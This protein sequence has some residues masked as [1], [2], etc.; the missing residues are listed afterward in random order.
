MKPRPKPP[1][2]VR[3]K[4]S[5]PELADMACTLRAGTVRVYGPENGFA[6]LEADELNQL[7]S[8]EQVFEASKTVLRQL[9]GLRKLRGLIAGEVEPT[10]IE[11]TN[12]TGH[13]ARMRLFYTSPHIYVVT[14]ERGEK[15]LHPGGPT[16]SEAW[17]KVARTNPRVHA[18][19][20]DLGMP[21]DLPRLR[22][23]FEHIWTELD[24]KN[25]KRAVEQMELA[26]LL[27]A[28]A[29]KR[30]LA[31]VNRSDEAAHSHF[32]YASYKKAFP[33]K[34]ATGWLFAV[35][36][37]WIEQKVSSGRAR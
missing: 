19:L 22:R 6:Y 29:A 8:P 36:N 31:T 11:W 28:D 37:Q 16:L 30:F 12:D 24:H 23:V 27:K 1:W 32:K 10:A 26:G 35:V 2:R 34:E 33:L 5:K 4:G 14:P 20:Q 9:L 13:W 3:L 25:Q 7:L 17:L 18:V 21:L 15:V